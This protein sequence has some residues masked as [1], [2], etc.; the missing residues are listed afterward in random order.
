MSDIPR[1]NLTYY[2]ASVWPAIWAKFKTSEWIFSAAVKT[3]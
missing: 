1:L 2:N 3:F